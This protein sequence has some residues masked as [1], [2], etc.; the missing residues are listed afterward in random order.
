[1]KQVLKRILSVLLVLVMMVGIIP[2]G[3]ISLQA[4]AANSIESLKAYFPPNSYWNHKGVSYDTYNANR[5]KYNLSSTNTPCEQ[6]PKGKKCCSING[7]NYSGS[8]GCNSFAGSTQCAGFARFVCNYLFGTTPDINGDSGNSWVRTSVDSLKIGDYVRYNGHS[9]VVY[10]VDDSGVTALE[11]NWNHTCKITW[12]RSISKKTLSSNNA[13]CLTYTGNTNSQTCTCATGYAGTY[14]TNNVSS[15]L[16]IRGGHGTGFASMGSIPA[17]AT[18]TVSKANGSWAHISYNGVNGY[19]SMDYIKKTGSS[20]GVFDGVKDFVNNLIDKL[21]PQKSGYVQRSITD[22]GVQFLKTREGCPT[23]NGRAYAYKDSVGVWTIGYGHTGGVYSGMTISMAEAEQYFRADI[24]KFENA[25]NSYLKKHNTYVTSYQFDALVSFTYNVGSAWC[26]DPSEAPETYKF[27]QTSN[28]SY[29]DMM[30]RFKYWCNPPELKN[31]R[32][33]EAKLYAYGSYDGKTQTAPEV[34]PIISTPSVPTPSNNYGRYKVHANGGLNVR[35]GPG[36]GYSKVGGLSNGTIVTINDIKGNWGKCSS[37]W[38]CLDYASYVGNAEPEIRVPGAPGIACYDGSHVPVDSN[39]TIS[40]KP[41]SDA[42]CYDVYLISSNGSVYQEQIGITGTSA[43]F[44]VTKADK[45]SVYAYARNTKYKSSKSNTTYFEACNPSTVKFIDHDGR[46][47]SQQTVRYGSSAVLPANPS[48]RGFTFKRWDGVYTNVVCDQIVEAVYERN[49]YTVTF[50]DETGAVLGNKQRVY[51]EGSATAPAYTAPEGYSF[52]KWDKD[53]NYVESNMTISPVIVWANDDLP[54][55]ILSTSTAVR[56]STGY[57]VNAAVRNNP[58]KATD[59][60]VIVALKTDD[61]K[62]LSMTESAA[63]H[64]SKSQNKTIEVFMPYDKA[65]SKAEIYVVETFSIAIPI[66]AV[67]SK[68]IDQGTAWTNWST[69]NNPADAYQAESRTEY[70]YRTKSTQTSTNSSLPGWTKYNTTSA[71]GNYGSWSGWTDTYIAGSDSRQVETRTV[72]VSDAYTK[73]HMYHYKYWNSKAGTY[74]YTWSPNMGGTC[75]REVVTW[76]RLTARSF[77]DN[78]AQSYRIDGVG[79]WYVEWEEN[80]PAVTKTQY[81]YRDRTLNYTYYY[82]KWS[83]WSAWSTTSV[84]A[85]STKEVQTRTTYRYLANDPSL[86]ADS[87]GTTRT[88]SGKVDPSLAGEQAI[89][90][91]YKVDEASDFTNEYVGQTKIG[92]DG[93]YSFSFKLREEPSIKTGD[94]TVTLG[95]EGTSTALFLDPILAPK[96]KYTVTYQDWDGRVI[97]TQQVTEGENAVMPETNPEREG[98]DFIC[99]NNTATNIKDD[100]TV[101]PVYKIK[102]YSV[103]FVDWTKENVVLETYEHGQPLV[104]PEIGNKD[105]SY[106]VGWDAIIDGT[107]TVT[108]NLIVTAKYEKKMYTVTVLDEKDEVLKTI[109][110]PYGESVDGPESVDNENVVVY[111]WWSESDMQSVK[112]DMTIIPVFEFKETTAIPMADVEQGEYTES[113]TVTLSCEDND[114]VIFYTI[115]GNDPKQNGIEYTEPILIDKTCE[116][117]FVACSFEKND[118]EVQNLMFA[119]NNS[120]ATEIM[121]IVTFSSNLIDSYDPIFVKH[122]ETVGI[123]STALQVEGY[124]YSQSTAFNENGEKTWDILNDTVTESINIGMLWTPKK[125][126]VTFIGYDDEVISETELDYLSDI[127]TP[128]CPN[129][130]GYVFAGFDCKDLVVRGNMTITANYIPEDEYVS[131]SINREKVR[132]LNGTSMNL[133]ATL[134]NC[135]NKDYTLLWASSNPDVV[136]VSDDGVIT[137]KGRG[138]AYV[139]VECQESGSTAVCEVTVVANINEQITINDGNGVGFDSANQIRGISVT[140]NTVESVR[141]MFANDELMFIDINGYVLENTDLVGTGTKIRLMNGSSIADEKTVVITGDM[142][143]DGKINN[144]DAS[145]I[146]RYLVDKEVASLAQLTAIDVNGDGNVNNRDASMVSRYLVGKEKI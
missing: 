62:L 29:E 21:L 117:K 70:R 5:N 107:E 92:N 12:N 75:Y 87:S 134:T 126:T 118:S 48:R 10:A 50:L 112:E 99:W 97:S 100:M 98:Y 133:T 4:N 38:I 33:L 140:N 49:L 145:M 34:S 84:G 57:T 138:S 91:I 40:W 71:W 11:C 37:G 120:S 30:G 106:S 22:A 43:A 59:G 124:D 77:D 46:V 9:I 135:S 14:T 26:Q 13:K 132:L 89:L 79:R 25:V 69:T 78:T 110:V 42:V 144:R 113:Q 123:S 58:N 105:D 94:Y 55:T 86:V 61:G 131:V 82:Y 19:V 93:S 53:F 24:K 65:A 85:T 143:G 103:V 51:F 142:N 63:F 83:D 111:D 121:H 125:Y 35:S 136:D 115:D 137:A 95:I 8:C 39:I 72:T 114:A 116:L 66:S 146:V 139:Y 3:G 20:T 1:M 102:T 73:V 90:F 2:L 15:T 47:L 60:R 109:E 108:Q 122:G 44:R 96:P 32:I 141:K 129:V 67:L 130:D 74:Y 31:R 27:F 28:H 119:I 36:T 128:N 88:I 52:L 23:R 80:V 81:R 7:R 6:H 17:G 18:F 76:D 127:V 101:S 64:L 54:V 45:Y 41:T 68:T 56:E 16:T 104:A